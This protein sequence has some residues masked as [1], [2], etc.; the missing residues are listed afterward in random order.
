MGS[1][2]ATS[3]GEVRRSTVQYPGGLSV[4]YRWAG[5]GQGSLVF[6]ETEAG[7]ELHDLG[8]LVADDP[9]P[10]CRAEL[11]V[12][13]P[14]GAWTLRLASRIYDEPA[15]LYWDAPALLVVK[16][17]FRV[18]ALERG[19]GE[20]RWSHSSGTPVLALFGSPRLPHVLV[21]SEIETFAL[22]ESGEVS[23]R[24]GHSDVVT[25]AEMVGGTLVLRSFGGAFQAI[26]PRTGRPAPEPAAHGD[27][28]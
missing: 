21:Q 6:G 23:W 15:A 17:G 14:L 7:G 3:A 18:Y 25:E 26:D 13:G 1:G 8:N 27:H 12:E 19:R 16:Y 11:R 2:P 24:I 5:S 28:G 20:L 22:E 10:L 9:D 4:R